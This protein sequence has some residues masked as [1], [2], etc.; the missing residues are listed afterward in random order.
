MDGQP[1]RYHRREDGTFLLY[2]VGEDGID[3]NGEPDRSGQAVNWQRD[4]DFV[5]PQAAPGDEVIAADAEAVAK[6]ATK[7][8][9]TAPDLERMMMK[10]YGLLPPD[11]GSDFFESPDQEPPEEE[12]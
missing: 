3:Q 7:A 12:P 8:A 1:L 2:S 6:A 10:R 11:A 5:W 4:Q 9:E